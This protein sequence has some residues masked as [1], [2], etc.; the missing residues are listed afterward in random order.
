MAA[1]TALSWALLAVA[2]KYALHFFSSGT[3]VWIRMLIAFLIL[4][5]FF[6]SRSRG[7][8]K[9]LWRPPFWGLVA[10]LLITINYYGFMKGIELTTASNAQIMIQLAPMGFMLLSIFALGEIPTPVQA[11]GMLTALLGLGFFFWD[12]ILVSWNQLEAFKQGNYWIVLAAVTWSVFAYLQKI[13][14]RTH[15]PQQF[16]LLI[17][18]L[19]A[20]LLWPTAEVGELWPLS[21]GQIALILF[22]ALNTV[23]AYG[24]LSEALQRIPSSHVSLVISVNPL[25]TLAIM[26]YLTHL[27]VTW[28]KGEP[29]YWRG[30]LGAILVVTG[31]IT[32]VS[33]RPA[34]SRGKTSA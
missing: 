5:V 11:T 3:I 10:G 21:W 9:I 8:L 28:I 18:G 16:N 6:A 27:E 4:F 33:S 29:I 31:V 23:V 15:K 24:A 34:L 13:I 32:T 12:Q 20:L 25:L 14:L 19:S 17:Y 30:F 7:Q 26:T 22:L 1:T 2:L